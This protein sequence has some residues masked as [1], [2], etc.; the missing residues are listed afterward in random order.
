M[1]AGFFLHVGH[2]KGAIEGALT[3]AGLALSGIGVGAAIL[4]LL[5][6]MNRPPPR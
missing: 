5:K 6:A 1:D 4:S 2:A 3:L